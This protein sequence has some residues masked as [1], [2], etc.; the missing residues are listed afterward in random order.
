MYIPMP[1][2]KVKKYAVLIFVLPLLYIFLTGKWY[3]NSL[4]NTFIFLPYYHEISKTILSF[5]IP[6]RLN[7]VLAGMDIYN[8][9]QFSPSYPFLFFWLP[10]Y[11]TYESTITTVT[12]V[13]LLHVFLCSAGA[14]LL[15]KYLTKS[16]ILGLLGG[17]FLGFSSTYQS[18]FNQLP[19][20]LPYCWIPITAYFLLR[21][22]ELTETH[23]KYDVVGLG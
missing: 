19:V 12:I 7:G 4:D 10:V 1:T 5:E 17:L 3:G 14:Y 8:I 9:P 22:L 16:I 11:G 13:T 21:L 15:F 23:N 18:Y 2:V 20:L 6:Y